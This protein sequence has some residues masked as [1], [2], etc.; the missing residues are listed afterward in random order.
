MPAGGPGHGQWYSPRDSHPPGEDEY[1]SMPSLPEPM[2]TVPSPNVLPSSREACVEC[3]GSAVLKYSRMIERECNEDA[4]DSTAGPPSAGRGEVAGFHSQ[5]DTLM[6]QMACMRCD[7]EARYMSLSRLVH[8]QVQDL[9]DLKASVH[10]MVHEA[11]SAARPEL[12]AHRDCE[13]DVEFVPIFTNSSRGQQQDAQCDAQVR[14][15]TLEN[16]LEELRRDLC[17]VASSV[18]GG[19]ALKAEPMHGC[20][21]SA[22]VAPTAFTGSGITGSAVG[23]SAVGTGSSEPF[24]V[25]A[26][27]SGRIVPSLHVARPPEAVVVPVGTVGTSMVPSGAFSMPVRSEAAPPWATAT[28]MPPAAT[29]VATEGRSV[30]VAPRVDEAPCQTP[31]GSRGG[32]SQFVSDEGRA[33]SPGK[34][35]QQTPAS[36]RGQERRG[37]PLPMNAATGFEGGSARV[38]PRDAPPVMQR[39]GG[40]ARFSP[41]DAPPMMHRERSRPGLLTGAG[42]LGSAS[43]C[44][45]GSARCP[46]QRTAPMPPPLSLASRMFGGGS[47]PSRRQS[48]SP[49]PKSP[50]MHGSMLSPTAGYTLG[51]GSVPAPTGSL[52]AGTLQS[53]LSLRQGNMPVAATH[54]PRCWPAAGGYSFDG[55]MTAGPPPPLSSRASAAR[56]RA[57]SGSPRESLMQAPQLPQQLQSKTLSRGQPQPTSSRS[58]EGQTTSL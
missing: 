4:S 32:V 41:R 27:G 39:E 55:A 47:S 40:S 26:A 17:R 6:E 53:S 36:A 24:S 14:I 48:T 20:A 35:G 56:F 57:N 5:I 16:D 44:G 31:P 22:T 33:W 51:G 23:S 46:G 50:C 28:A 18:S 34:V 42:G 11:V 52:Q 38:S 8:E 43:G 58:L 2:P 49:G 37:L 45:G 12:S 25:A 30:L 21:S 7:F 10:D 29:V 13:D 3:V 15:A 1:E 9:S 54:Q 19:P